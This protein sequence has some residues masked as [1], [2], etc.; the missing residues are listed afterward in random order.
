[1]NK[2]KSRTNKLAKKQKPKQ[3]KENLNYTQLH[4]QRRR[5]HLILSLQGRGR[6]SGRTKIE[7]RN[8][9]YSLFKYQK[10]L[11]IIY[12]KIINIFI[13]KYRLNNNQ[14]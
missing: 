7:T 10:I 6:R 4:R 11:Y 1:M 8:K 5:N 13:L 9:T 12:I 2:S 3:E 14:K